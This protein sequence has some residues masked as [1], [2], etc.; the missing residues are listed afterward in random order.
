MEGMSDSVS[1]Y[2]PSFAKGLQILL[3]DDDPMPLVIMATM[4]EQ[5]SF[6]KLKETMVQCFVFHIYIYISL[7][8][9]I[10]LRYFQR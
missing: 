10:S 4:L 3:G 5:C 6:K 8:F 1:K 9:D 7:S 2:V